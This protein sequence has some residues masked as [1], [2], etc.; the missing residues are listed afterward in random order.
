MLNRK[1]I[2]TVSAMVATVGLSGVANAETEA[3]M[4]GSPPCGFIEVARTEKRGP[5]W[6]I[7]FKEWESPECVNARKIF[8]IKPDEEWKEHRRQIAEQ[9]AAAEQARGRMETGRAAAETSHAEVRNG[10][11]EADRLY[12]AELDRTIGTQNWTAY[13]K[14]L[15]AVEELRSSYEQHNAFYISERREYEAQLASLKALQTGEATG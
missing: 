15:R 7:D 2:V 10:L 9:Q 3:G 4:Y 13:K 12:L 6:R 8:H 5:A 11:R 14:Q 1:N